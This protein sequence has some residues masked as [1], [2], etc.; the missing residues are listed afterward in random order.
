MGKYGK[1]ALQATQGTRSTVISKAGAALRVE[2][3]ELSEA[4]RRSLTTRASS[5]GTSV[6]LP[7]AST[8]QME[9]K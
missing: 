2:R 3:I 9:Q 4:D 7:E 1:P 8:P 6:P 5:I